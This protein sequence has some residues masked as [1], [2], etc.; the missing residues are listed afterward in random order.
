MQLGT[1]NRVVRQAA[2]AGAK[3]LLGWLGERL[4]VNREPDPVVPRRASEFGMY[5]E[6][7]WYRLALREERQRSGDPMRRVPASL[8]NECILRP[9]LGRHGPEWDDRIEYV[10]G[11]EGPAGIE[12]RVG[13]DRMA[14]GFAL[15]PTAIVDVMAVADAGKVMPAKSTFFEPK[16]ADGL[17]SYL[18]GERPPR[19][20]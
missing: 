9:L 19:Q 16:P 1:Y 4:A 15:H 7:A 17:I 5:L 20:R 13:A 2:T 3:A 6:G 11:T 8:L 12:R 18:L 14:A 10:E